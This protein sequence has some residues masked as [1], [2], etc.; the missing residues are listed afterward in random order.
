MSN[1]FSRLGY[2]AIAKESTAGTAVKPDTYVEILS[3]NIVVN[4]PVTPVT[5]IA[6]RRDVNKTSAKEKIE[7]SGDITVLV[8]AKNIGEFLQN[9]AGAPST[10]TIETGKVYQHVWTLANTDEKTYTIDVKP[11]DAD[12][13]VRVTGVKVSQ[14]AFSQSDN[15]IQC[16]VS[17][18]GQIAFT[19][20]RATAVLGNGTALVVDQSS[21]LVTSDILRIIDKDTYAVKDTAS[22]SSIDSETGITLG[23]N[24]TASIDDIITIQKSTPTYTQSKEMTFIGGSTFKMMA[25]NNYYNPINNT[26]EKNLEDFTLNFLNELE[27]RYTAKGCNLAD[28]FPDSIKV[29]GFTA[30]GNIVNI[31]TTSQRIDDMRSNEQVALRFDICGSQLDTNSAVASSTTIGSGDSQINIT[32][33]VASETGSDLN[34]T[35]INNTDDSLVASKTGNNILVKLASTTTTSNT[36]TLVAA[37]IDA[38]SGVGASSPTGTGLVAVTA[39]KNLT[40]GRNA[41]EK[42]LLRFDLNHVIF[43]PYA[44]N[45]SE[46]DLIQE[47]I[48]FNAY[49]DSTDSR[50]AKIVLRNDVA[51][52]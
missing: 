9:F 40:G 47:D 41:N 5:S 36:G 39:K 2:L 20:A 3:E 25:K 6:G 26:E 17:V 29:K 31:Y 27:A 37:A 51:N 10:T 42:E 8:E 28:R 44:A 50:T 14:L 48:P 1:P 18:M 7:I 32:A 4:Y 33:S 46:D 15:K 52:Y 34:V 35:I 43:D 21:G 49:F 13:V 12:H 22:I 16:V 19:N 23:E 45:I 30:N 38:L 11:A 24:A